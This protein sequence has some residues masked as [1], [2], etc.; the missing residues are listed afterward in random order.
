MTHINLHTPITKGFYN[1][2]Q[3]LIDPAETV[4]RAWQH[5]PAMGITRI[6][7]VTGLDRIGIHVVMVSRPNA[8][9][10]SVSQG[11][12]LTLDAAKA[13]GIMEAIEGYHAESILKPLIQGSYDELSAAGYSLV[14]V[15]RLPKLRGKNYQTH[16]PLLWIEGFDLLNETAKWV[17]YQVVHTIYT[18]PTV[19]LAGETPFVMTSNGLASGNHL[20]EAIV[21]AINELVERDATTL[22]DLDSPENKAKTTLDQA[23]ITAPEA[24]ALLEQLDAAKIDVYIWHQPTDI[25]LPT[26]RC[27]IYERT[28]TQ[29]QRRIPFVGFG[30]HLTK[31][32]ALTRALTEAVQSRLIYIAGVRDDLELGL[33]AVPDLEEQ[34]GARK[35]ARDAMQGMVD[36][37][38][39]ADNPH[40]TFNEDLRFQL[41]GLCKAGIEE[42]IAIDLTQPR[43]DIPVVRVVIPGLEATQLIGA[44]FTAGARGQRVLQARN[45]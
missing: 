22:W 34:L 12:G 44:Q 19:T 9:S 28:L 7:N 33:Y 24:T 23:S 14:D 41:D 16:M 10:I 25:G 38:S 32:I 6:A 13:S 4:A 27:E 29:M 45:Q 40:D 35:Q 1:G 43:F 30:T 42:V 31:S 20:L 21:H 15:S 39:L 26:F 18:T 8:K 5:A 2:T 11:K 17:P 37:A 36:Y 3:R